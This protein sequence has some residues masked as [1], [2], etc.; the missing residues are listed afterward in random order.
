[1]NSSLARGNYIPILCV[2]LYTNSWFQ[3]KVCEDWLAQ[4]A[5]SL[6]AFFLQQLRHRPKMHLFPWKATENWTCT[7]SL[8]ENGSSNVIHSLIGNLDFGR[9]LPADDTWAPQ[10]FT[11]GFPH[12]SHL[13]Y[14]AAGGKKNCVS[15]TLAAFSGNIFNRS[16]ISRFCSGEKF[17]FGLR[18]LFFCLF[19]D[20]VSAAPSD[21][22]NALFWQT[23]FFTSDVWL[24]PLATGSFGL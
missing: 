23:V 21:S 8:Q 1:M 16:I 3:S 12:C 19:L 14:L 10:S 22:S 5:T 24:F 15:V 6:K 4:S 2:I 18:D 9:I 13:M 20:N 7:D 11:F 17:L